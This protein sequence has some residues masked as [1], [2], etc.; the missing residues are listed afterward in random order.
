MRRMRQGEDKENEVVPAKAEDGLTRILDGIRRSAVSDKPPVAE[1]PVPRDVEMA[2]AVPLAVAPAVAP[3]VTLYELQPNA[4][5]FPLS[6]TAFVATGNEHISPLA[7]SSVAESRT[8][9]LRLANGIK[10]EASPLTV[11]DMTSPAVLAPKSSPSDVP[12]PPSL[13]RPTLHSPPQSVLHSPKAQRAGVHRV[14]KCMGPQMIP[15]SVSEPQQRS[16]RRGG[17]WKK[18]RPRG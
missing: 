14:S 18:Y 12:A 1:L 16:N 10:R 6:M 13:P 5:V 17:P 9:S 8:P 2:D 4:K 15:A 11:N 3:I 7:V